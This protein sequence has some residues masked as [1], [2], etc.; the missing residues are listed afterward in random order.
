MTW[1]FGFSLG[2]EV[3]SDVVSV[4]CMPLG[5]DIS[6]RKRS[7]TTFNWPSTYLGSIACLEIMVFSPVSI[8]FSGSRLGWNLQVLL[9]RH[10]RRH[11][12]LT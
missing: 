2:S 5:V 10:E 1:S 12:L 6:P 4:L 3:G 9:R 8:E 11:N 7:E